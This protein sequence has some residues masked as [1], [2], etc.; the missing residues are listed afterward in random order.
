MSWLGT[1][2]AGLG[3][4]ALAGLAGGCGGKPSP[5]AAHTVEINGRTWRVELATTPEQR[6]RGLSGRKR[7]ADDAGMLFIFP[8]PEVQDFCMRECL[9]PLDIAFIGADLRVV[10][11]HTM[12]V[13]PDRLGT[14]SYPS[15]LPAQYALEVPAG[16]LA[17][18][19][20]RVGQ[21]VTFSPG[22]PSPVKAQGSP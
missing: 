9:I 12:A 14:V 22:I 20:V 19:G 1:I 16:S 13:E 5:P 2:L 4:L 18:A 17:R 15:G 10:K 21:K 6:Y 11:T 8:L 7:L 3:M